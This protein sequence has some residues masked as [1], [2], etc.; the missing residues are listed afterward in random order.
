MRVNLLRYA[1]F[2]FL[3]DP[4]DGFFKES[5]QVGRQGQNW[6]LN[7]PALFLNLR[8]LPGGLQFLLLRRDTGF[9]DGKRF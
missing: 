4:F 3:A 9:H 7:K 6:E 2:C 5:A 1:N 8:G